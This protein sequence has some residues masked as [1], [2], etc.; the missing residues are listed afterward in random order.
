MHNPAGGPGGVSFWAMLVR[1]VSITISRCFA[2]A[3]IFRQKANRAVRWVSTSGASRKPAR[4]LTRSRSLAAMA[5]ASRSLPTTRTISSRRVA[6][7]Y[8]PASRKVL[9]VC[10]D[11]NVVIPISPDVD[12]QTGKADVAIK[13]D[14][15]PEFLA[16]DGQGKVYI[17]LEDKDQVAVVDTKAMKVINRWL[18]HRDLLVV[19]CRLRLIP[20]TASI[21][22]RT[23]RGNGPAGDRAVA[24]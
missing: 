10:G 24:S 14:G 3:V 5:S 4:S 16:A 13:L 2:S 15:K 19:W 23:W 22:A 7:I 18:A 12:P 6:I 8:D 9:V 17:N 20:Q 21:V 11:A 1:S